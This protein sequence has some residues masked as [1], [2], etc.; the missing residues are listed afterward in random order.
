M[1]V[2]EREIRRVLALAEPAGSSQA[3]TGRAPTRKTADLSRGADPSVA[4]E[5]PFNEHRF[6][7]LRSLR[8]RL[9][10]GDYTVNSYRIADK[11]I[12]RALCDQIL[13]LEEG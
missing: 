7:R 1:I 2:S 5:V 6:F 11:M 3:G 9:A 12:G 8:D 4:A 10:A 13:R